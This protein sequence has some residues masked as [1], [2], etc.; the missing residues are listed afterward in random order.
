MEI[1][2]LG[3]Y[4]IHIYAKKF[5]F[6]D[7]YQPSQIQNLMHLIRAHSIRGQARYCIVLD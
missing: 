3:A 1:R 7:A 5:R 6:R 2:S 4:Y